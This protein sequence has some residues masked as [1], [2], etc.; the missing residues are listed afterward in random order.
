MS[1]S[2]TDPGE[3]SS[4]QLERE[5]DQQRA[6]VSSTVDAL[7]A[8]ISVKGI[9]NGIIDVISEHGGDISRNLGETVKR[10]PLP[11]LLTGIG[12]A[13]LIAGTNRQG[14]SR[15][16]VSRDDTRPLSRVTPAMES[17]PTAYGAATG[18]TFGDGNS[19]RFADSSR[20]ENSGDD[21]GES[22]RDKTSDVA[23]ATAETVKG[24]ARSMKETV[25]EA[26]DH[27]AQT[28]SKVADKVSETT[29]KARNGFEKTMDENPLVL[30]ALALAAGA[31]I[32]GA[33]PRTQGEDALLGHHSDRLK[34][35]AQSMAREQVEK[36]KAVGEKVAA[37]ARVV[38]DEAL[39]KLDE[40]A[41]EGETLANR[42]G[43]T[44]RNA[45]KRLEETAK[46]EAEKQDLG[47]SQT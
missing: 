47:T 32:A 17:R 15:D 46:E 44:A 28:A 21:S 31:A 43:N 26:G 30:G 37:E 22:L 36:T 34:D 40:S 35:Q 4:A 2:E 42:A 14:N 45:A 38:A 3:K 33:L 29:L 6:H 5:V 25:G 7:Q 20:G 41:P 9:A 16:F 23:S 13:W 27:A 24:K 12:L 39:E 19:P 8:K 18:D 11:L 1:V 10:N